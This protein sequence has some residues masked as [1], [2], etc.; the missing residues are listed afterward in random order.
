M[1]PAISDTLPDKSVG[2][3]CCMRFLPAILVFIVMGA[4]LSVAR[5]DAAD[6]KKAE[7]VTSVPAPVEIVWNAF[8]DADH[9]SQWMAPSVEINLAIGGKI[10]ANYNP[11]QKL[12]G[13]DTI[14]NT[15]LAYDPEKMLALR[16]TKFPDSYPWK[17]EAG[18]TWAV[19]YFT[20]LSPEMTQIKVVGLGYQ[21]DE[22]S[23][24]MRQFFAL[25]NKVS[26]DK[27]IEHL[28][29]VESK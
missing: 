29:P 24:K 28:T 2:D 7:Y 20:E 23:Q 8:T 25:A 5:V 3:K 19:F 14:E 26:L 4:Q 17:K 12:G 10:R 1:I 18:L 15:I 27:L 9:L 13:P 21:M 16:V 6:F 11:D 22:N